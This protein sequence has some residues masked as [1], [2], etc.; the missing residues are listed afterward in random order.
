M[1][2]RDPAIL[3]ML[4]RQN[5]AARRLY[6]DG[7]PCER[8][9]TET[10]TLIVQ[11]SF[12]TLSVRYI[13]RGKAQGFGKSWSVKFATDKPKLR[14]CTIGLRACNSLQVARQQGGRSMC[15]RFTLRTNSA[16]LVEVFEHP[17]ERANG[18]RRSLTR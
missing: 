2:Q 5:A 7:K 1:A 15:G 11:A 10:D 4:R 13:R 6:S 9:L 8:T 3:T 16:D 17:C 18:I 14:S 12:D